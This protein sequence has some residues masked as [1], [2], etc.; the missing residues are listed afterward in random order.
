MKTKKNLPALCLRSVSAALALCMGLPFFAA[1][2]RDS[3]GN[4]STADTGAASPERAVVIADGKSKYSIRADRLVKTGS[5]SDI[6][7]M[8][9]L[10]FALYGARLELSDT[11][12]PYIE[13]KYDGERTDYSVDFDPDTGNIT[14]TGGLDDALR[15][16]IY[17]FCASACS[18]AAAKTGGELTVGEEI[19]MSYTHKTDATDNSSLLSYIPTDK[20]KLVAGNASGSIMTPE[21]VESLV[22]VELRPDTASIGGTLE[23]S[24]AL[25]DF[26]ANIGVNGIWLVPIYERGPGGNGYGNT[27]PDRVDPVFSGTD[28]DGWDAVRDFVDYAHSKGVYIFLDIIT[29]GVMYDTRLTVEHS[30]WFSGSLWNNAAFNWKNA[31]LREWFISTC[32]ENIIKTG[33]D[34]YR[35]DCEPGITGYDIYGEIRSRLAA[36]GKYIIIISEDGSDRSR[37]YDFEQDGVLKYSAMTRGGYYQN[38]VNFFTDGYL[39]LVTSVKTGE[40]LGYE[41]GQKDAATVGRGKYY[42]NCITNH[43]FQKRSVKG[44]RAKI[45]YA[46]ILAPF[47]PLWYMGDEFNASWKP[48]VIYDLP[49]N[50]SE[51]NNPEKA[52]FL[53]DV[54]RYVK[55]RRTY[56]DIFEY[57]ADDHR[58]SNITA[59]T[60]EGFG[61]LGAYARY[62]DGKAVLVVANNDP[63]GIAAGSVTVPFA[64]CGLG[65]AE[66]YT[67]TDLMSGK[68]IA[69]GTAGEIGTFRAVLPAG[70]VGVYLVE[71]A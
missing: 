24:R 13:L 55:I 62:A 7:S 11:A 9:D 33:A 25:V 8:N 57:W 64:E 4:D 17:A 50:Y 61:T 56:S 63:A 51:V 53:E 31:E 29:W 39:D 10:F 42:T 71:K 27:G 49:V 21:W 3:G 14:L 52:F 47:I 70:Y 65:E 15:R 30:D 18:G 16:A 43:D 60:T 34:G 37:T 2:G 45:G 6:E 36:K 26:Y 67:V 68:V 12:E 32:V 44:S 46:A 19:D 41:G 35:C 5:A 58:D 54:R 40:G 38:P 22:M 1:C 59:V 23:K 69:A 28:G 66:K 48:A 20:V